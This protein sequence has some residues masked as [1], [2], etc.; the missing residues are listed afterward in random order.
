MK[1]YSTHHNQ[2]QNFGVNAPK[3]FIEALQTGVTT[4][5]YKY[6]T[7]FKNT[8]K[9]AQNLPKIGSKNTIL[10]KPLITRGFIDE[11]AKDNGE[12]S[13]VFTFTLKTTNP[14]G[15]VIKSKKSLA[16]HKTGRDI[17]KDFSL[18]VNSFEEDVINNY[19]E[20]MIKRGKLHIA[21][22]RLIK[23]FPNQE[24]YIDSLVDSLA[25]KNRAIKHK[26]QKMSPFAKF[27]YNLIN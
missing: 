9:L 4:D 11:F 3:V 12:L 21:A 2:N 22:F 7:F 13:D 14:E 6:E 8:K 23:I 1:I 10:E 24:R 18:I 20:K 25:K 26:H 19:V 16:A 17:E 15:K 5:C 27:F